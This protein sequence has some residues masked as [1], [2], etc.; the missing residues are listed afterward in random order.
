MSL[1]VRTW[2]QLLA[3]LV[4]SCYV[5][6]ASAHIEDA[7]AGFTSGLLHPVLGMDHFLAMFSVGIV[8]AQLGGRYI[9]TV[10]L[11]FVLA[12]ISGGAVGMAQVVMPYAEAGIALSVMVLG[13]AIVMAR[14]GGRGLPTMLVTALFGF[15][16]GH[17]HGMEMPQA[18]D[19]V[20]YAAGFVFSTATIHLAGVGVGHVL[21]RQSSSLVLL[22]FLG[23]AM[24]CAGVVILVKGMA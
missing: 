3:V 14:H 15:L 4:L 12:M 13:M 23:S 22:R 16:H 11:A 6:Q 17:A 5:R 10:P 18:A 7:A 9:Y 20:Y 8:S 21:T 24:A 19:P 2:C 1:N